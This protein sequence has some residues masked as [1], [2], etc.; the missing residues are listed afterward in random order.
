MLDI[1]GD[2]RK[3]PK[4]SVNVKIK[5]N[6]KYKEESLEWNKVF[7]YIMKKPRTKLEFLMVNSIR[8]LQLSNITLE[9][10]KPYISEEDYGQLF[11][12]E[13]TGFIIPQYEKALQQAEIFLNEINKH[14]EDQREKISSYQDRIKHLTNSL[15]TCQKIIK[16]IQ[17]IINI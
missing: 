13:N 8:R 14:I 11:K 1:F 7:G 12:I 3:R 16:D 15:K 17:K 2:G 5:I 6:T 4:L 10:I 9:K